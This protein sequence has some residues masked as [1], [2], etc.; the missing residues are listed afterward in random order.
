MILRSLHFDN[1]GEKGG[2]T[3]I[4]NTLVPLHLNNKPQ[5]ALTLAR[6]DYEV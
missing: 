2:S 5:T 3:S 6:S 1:R 4:R